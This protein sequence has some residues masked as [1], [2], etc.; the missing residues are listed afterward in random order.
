MA[1][2][3]ST[4]TAVLA[5]LLR[6]EL[7]QGW[8]DSLPKVDSIFKYIVGTSDGVERDSI[9]RG[10]NIKHNFRTGLAGAMKW[11]SIAG[12]ATLGGETSEP[13]RQSIAFSTQQSFPGVSDA[14]STGSVTRTLGMAKLL[15]NF[16]LP[17]DYFKID[18]LNAMVIGKVSADIEGTAQNLAHQMAVALYTAANMEL[19]DIS[20]ISAYGG[21]AAALTFTP[22][23]GRIR[24]FY[25]GLSVDVYDATRVTHRNAAF[26]LVVDGVD[27]LNGTVRLV[28][29]DG[30][31]IPVGFIN[32]DK[33]FVADCYSATKIGPYAID[34]WTATT[35]TIF[36]S[37]SGL[38]LT[39]YPQFKSSVVNLA[40][41]LTDGVLTYR[42]GRFFD[43]YGVWLDT[44]LTTRGVS[45]KYVQQPSF[46]SGNFLYERQG[47]AL[48]FKGG[49]EAEPEYVYDGHSFRWLISPYQK[50]GVVHILKL[51]DGNLRRYMPPRLAKAGSHGKFQ[52]VEFFAPLGGHTGIFKAVHTSTGSTSPMVE[53]PFTLR[54]QM[55]PL[56]PRGIKLYGVTEST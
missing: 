46:T 47:K 1:A 37:S 2:V 32:T 14:M 15:G 27:Y 39:Y 43:A 3:T 49:T 8:T 25:N 9:G 53:A 42:I 56:D 24:W 51:N 18:A 48:R 52:D 31:D 28:R 29:P 21:A 22:S 45:E 7:P 36:D 16:Y 4:T 23:G 34:D 55:A 11:V 19:C 33:V 26:P 5:N 40:A 12:G 41:A 38:N 54:A 30:T 35:G 10:W 20:S 13:L 6:E 50:T 17:E 44:I